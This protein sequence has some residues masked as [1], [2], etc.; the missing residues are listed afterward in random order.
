MAFRKAISQSELA[1][2]LSDDDR[3]QHGRAYSAQTGGWTETTTVKPTAGTGTTDQD[4]SGARKW[5]NR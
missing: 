3:Q 2:S 1:E 4:A 5:W